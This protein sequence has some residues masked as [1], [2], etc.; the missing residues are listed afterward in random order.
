MRCSVFVAPVI[1]SNASSML[2]PS[3]QRKSVPAVSTCVPKM[4]R[5]HCTV[6]P[7]ASVG[8]V[9]FSVRRPV[10]RAP[11]ASGIARKLLLNVFVSPKIV[12]CRVLASGSRARTPPL[13]YFHVVSFNSS[14]NGPTVV[15]LPLC[16]SSWK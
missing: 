8:T 14:V 5:D 4:P 16:R 3:T 10:A 15:I 13:V 6:P 1:G 2:S 11:V 7:K 9:W 12:A